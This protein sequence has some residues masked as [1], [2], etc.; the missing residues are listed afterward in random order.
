M[1][2]AVGVAFLVIAASHG[3]GFHFE[4]MGSNA[5]AGGIIGVML[6]LG[7]TGIWLMSYM[8]CAKCGA[9]LNDQ[10]PRTPLTGID[11]LLLDK[12]SRA[13]VD[14]AIAGKYQCTACGYWN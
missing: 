11:G 7:A 2:W 10:L 3:L 1:H 5:I 4:W 14:I 9:K 13:I 12:R 6:V 8:R